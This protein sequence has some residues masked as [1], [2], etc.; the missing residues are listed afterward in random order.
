MR[1]S[2]FSTAMLELTLFAAGGSAVACECVTPSV[3]GSPSSLKL[4]RG[5]RSRT[6]DSKWSED[7]YRLQ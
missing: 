1:L 2:L 5:R 4:K 7:M 6:D 3:K